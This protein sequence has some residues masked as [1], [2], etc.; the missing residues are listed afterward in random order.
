LQNLF[1]NF[2]KIFSAPLRAAPQSRNR[3]Q[4]K[5]LTGVPRW[6]ILKIEKFE[7]GLVTPLSDSEK[8]F[9]DREEAYLA[10]GAGCPGRCTYC[11]LTECLSQPIPVLY[12]NVGDMLEE[13]AT[14]LARK[15]NVY[16]HLGHILD[17]LAY[18]LAQPLLEGFIRAVGSSPPT[19]LEIRTKFTAVDLLPPSP[20]PNVVVAFS[21]S[22]PD[23]ARLYEK[24]TST[25]RARLEAAKR[26]SRKGYKIGIRLDPVLIRPDRPEAYRELSSL[27]VQTFSTHEVA[28]VVLGCFR[29]P[30]ALIDRVRREDPGSVFRRGEFVPIGEGK[31]GYPRP[32]RLRALRS[33]A[34]RLGGRFPLRLC[35]EDH[36]VEEDLFS[37][38]PRRLSP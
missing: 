16:L 3:T 37:R 18:P 12:G 7:G 35:F 32:L 10:C 30:P 8:S 29:G 21:F 24:G 31:L 23:I 19:R 5:V 13:F 15:P 34:A 20:P 6:K 36:S 33:L 27:L 11:V 25:L 26:V 17:P 1:S 14:Y 28:D 4:P 22:P 9:P 2:Q 38:R